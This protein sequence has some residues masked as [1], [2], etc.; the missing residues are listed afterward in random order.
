MTGFDFGNDRKKAEGPTYHP[1]QKA[2]LKKAATEN[3]STEALFNYN[4]KSVEANSL[5][6]YA[7]Y[8][9]GG[10]NV[11]KKVDL[12]ALNGVLTDDQM[13]MVAKFVTPAQEERIEAGVQAGRDFYENNFLA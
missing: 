8:A 6:A 13:A 12:G 9:I 10:M 11:G 5:D 7:N 3:K 2:E 4:Q 1:Q